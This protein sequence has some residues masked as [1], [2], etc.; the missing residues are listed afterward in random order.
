MER[1]SATRVFCS[2]LEEA[3]RAELGVMERRGHNKFL[4]EHQQQPD[5]RHEPRDR[6]GFCSSPCW[7]KAVL[8]QARLPRRVIL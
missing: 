7:P 8:Q 2:V 3:L 5:R 1:C 6:L 4:L